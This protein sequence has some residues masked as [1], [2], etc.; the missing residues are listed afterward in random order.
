[1]ILKVEEKEGEWKAEGEV[2]AEN[3]EKE[4]TGAHTYMQFKIF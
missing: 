3:T 2:V 1:M 4:M